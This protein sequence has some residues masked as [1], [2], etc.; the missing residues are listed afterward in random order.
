MSMIGADRATPVSRI[1]RNEL[2]ACR[3]NQLTSSIGRV[4]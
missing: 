3:W 2:A 1:S 4:A